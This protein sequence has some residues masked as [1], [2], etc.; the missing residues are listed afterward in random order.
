M[1][2]KIKIEKIRKG[3]YRITVFAA[4]ILLLSAAAGWMEATRLQQGIAEEVLRFHVLA[5][6]DSE[7]DQKIK[8]EVRDGIL[9]WIQVHYESKTE[10]KVSKDKF[11]KDDKV[12]MM[13]FLEENQ[14]EIVK[15]ANRILKLAGVSYH[16]QAEMEQCYFPVRTYGVCTFPAGWYD[17]FRICLGKA[18]GKNWWCVLYPRLC[19]SDYLHVVAQED[20]LLQLE[21]VLTVEE[22]EW[23]LRK[24]EKWKIA[25]RW[26]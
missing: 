20:A 25:F 7:S 1:L 26:F 12:K 14:E 15:E 16:A 19:F 10:R 9:E 11:A 5:N 24:P 3:L 23:I 13:R 17:A 22:Y 8:L 2:K 21:D 18:E 4:L 6:S